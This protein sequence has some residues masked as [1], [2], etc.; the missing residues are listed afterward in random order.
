[1]S[2]I[3]FTQRYVFIRKMQLYFIKY[4]Y[5]SATTSLLI[6]TIQGF[7]LFHSCQFPSAKQPIFASVSPPHTGKKSCQL[8]LS[9]TR[10]HRLF[11]QR[12]LNHNLLLKRNKYHYQLRQPIIINNA[13]SFI[14]M[15]YVYQ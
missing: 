15:S 6:R 14:F 3:L 11:E 5:F 7:R 4:L 9:D 2:L 1:M 8:K 12:T 10:I 13:I